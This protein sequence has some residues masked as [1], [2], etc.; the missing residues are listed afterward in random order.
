MARRSLFSMI[1]G[2]NKSTYEPESS[3]QLEL[4]E[5]NKAVFTPY[6][7]DFYNDPDVLACVDAIARNGAK[8]HPRHIR[9]YFS[10]EENRE[11]LE[12]VKSS[13]Y[14]LLA[15]QPNEIQN[16]YKFYYEVL[17]QLELYNNAFIYVM[18]D[19]DLKII[20]LYPLCYN[21]I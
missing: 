6:K 21:E 10:K 17:T 3:E 9:N 4:V 19:E 20:G 7:G 16:A 14:K 13:L 8:M 12:N 2:N 5:G 1:F 11:K 18:K 15:K